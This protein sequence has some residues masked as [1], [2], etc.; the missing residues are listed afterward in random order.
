MS[1]LDAIRFDE[2]GLVTVVVQDSAN[3]RVLAAMRAHPQG[4]ES[5]VIGTVTEDALLA[6]VAAAGLT[7]ARIV[8]CV[9]C[10]QGTPLDRKFGKSLRV[11]AVTLYARK[12][13]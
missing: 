8:E 3:G 5:A 7:D 13:E 1:W 9:H 11:Y 2:R 6:H 10:F 12:P 4:A